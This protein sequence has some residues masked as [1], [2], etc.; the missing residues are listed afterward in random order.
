LDGPERLSRQAVPVSL[1]VG[2]RH[3]VVHTVW[4]LGNTTTFEWVRQASRVFTRTGIVHDHDFDGPCW[5][6]PL[7]EVFDRI[8]PILPRARMG[9]LMS[10][11]TMKSKSLLVATHVVV[12]RRRYLAAESDETVWKPT[13][14]QPRRS[15]ERVKVWWI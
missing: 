1:T 11:A 15:G 13:V 14:W 4:A 3:A 10:T 6:G 5:I 9:I 8:F 12:H 7:V 2:G